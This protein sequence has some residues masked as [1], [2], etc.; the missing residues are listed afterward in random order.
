MLLGDELD[1]SSIHF[2]SLK[3]MQYSTSN[4]ILWKISILLGWC[5]GKACRAIAMIVAGG[6]SNTISYIFCLFV[7]NIFLYIG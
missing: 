2:S 1:I 5:P 3:P 7:V 6:S 4:N